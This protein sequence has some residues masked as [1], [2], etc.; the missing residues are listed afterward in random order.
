MNKMC[1]IHECNI[2]DT[3]Q[4]EKCT[5]RNTI[6]LLVAATDILKHASLYFIFIDV[7]RYTLPCSS[8]C[9]TNYP[10]YL[11]FSNESCKY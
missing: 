6:I 11:I 2:N 7:C 1:I 4:E 10:P 9:F 8:L 3:Q 5:K